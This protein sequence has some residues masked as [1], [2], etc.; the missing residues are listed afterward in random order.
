VQDMD[1]IRVGPGLRLVIQ[2]I[3][4]FTENMASSTYIDLVDTVMATSLA[5][6]FIAPK[7]MS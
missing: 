1:R 2:P 5:H 4:Q 6:P 3:Q 7:L